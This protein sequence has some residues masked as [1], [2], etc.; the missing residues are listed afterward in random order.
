MKNIK[1]E[2]LKN[3]RDLGGI[4]T[5]NGIIK[6]KKMIRAAGLSGLTSKDVD[7]LLDDYDE[8]AIIDLRTEEEIDERPDVE[9]PSAKYFQ[10]PVLTS[11]AF[12]ITHEEA[13]RQ[14]IDKEVNLRDFYALAFTDGYIENIRNIIKTILFLENEGHTVIFHCT[15]GKDRT[16]VV[17]AVLLT[18]LGVDR[19]TIMEDYLYT[20]KVNGKKA[21]KYYWAIRLLEKNKK[22][23]KTVKSMY[24]A[25]RD[26]MQAVFDTIDENWENTEDFI[27]NGLKLEE[28]L[29]NQFEKRVVKKL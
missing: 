1:F 24:I 22:K 20:N 11:E 12:G 29:I 26:Y 23:A 10:M 16:G 15:E 14:G 21:K 2:G 5:K 25:D 4:K 28:D 6:S 8:L 17:A 3:T 19:E 27:K 7:K 18:I 9:I 13:A